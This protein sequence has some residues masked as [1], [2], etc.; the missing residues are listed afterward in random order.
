MSSCSQIDVPV[1]NPDMTE[2]GITDIM[3]THLTEGA[4]TN[5]TVSQSV[6]SP[7]LLSSV[8]RNLQ[9]IEHQTKPTLRIKKQRLPVVC[10]GGSPSDSN[11]AIPSGRSVVRPTMLSRVIT[12]KNYN[13][14]TK[15]IKQSANRVC[16]E[17]AICCK[18]NVENSPIAMASIVIDP[19]SPDDEVK[20]R[21]R[22]HETSPFSTSAHSTCHMDRRKCRTGIEDIPSSGKNR[23]VSPNTASVASAL[24]LLSRLPFLHRWPTVI[25]KKLR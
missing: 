6:K 11:P 10:K 1:V 18:E 7:L 5:L 8:K 4:L 22:N 14:P 23:F 19:S 9:D 15:L 2:I 25:I 21:I 16:P 24:S 12:I 17:K 3:A 13:R 20:Q